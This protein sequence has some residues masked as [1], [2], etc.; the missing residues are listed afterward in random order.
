MSSF[1]YATSKAKGNKDNSTIVYPI[2]RVCV[3]TLVG[4]L[5]GQYLP[6]PTNR[7]E[8]RMDSAIAKKA[9]K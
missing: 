8:R 7:H 5:A 6:P 9:A 2:P 3:G 1:K 4:P